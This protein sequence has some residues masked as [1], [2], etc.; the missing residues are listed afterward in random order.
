VDFYGY[1]YGMARP[2][3]IPSERKTVDIR[4]PMTEDQKKTISAAAEAEQA[5]VATW[6]RPILLKIAED[7]L[8]KRPAR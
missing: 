6:A 2:L 5:D 4:I 1:I 3:K 8:R 7:R